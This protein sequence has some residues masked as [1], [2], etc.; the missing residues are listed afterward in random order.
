MSI[1]EMS[2]RHWPSVA[3]AVAL[4][5]LFGLSSIA[6]L[7]IQ[8]LPT[9][10][11]PQV[12]VANFWRAA[13]P[14]EMEANIIEPQENVLRNTPGLTNIS[15]FIG[16][17]QGFIN[18][19][20]AIGTDILR[21]ERVDKVVQRLGDRFVRRILTPE[22]CEE[23]AASPR[24]N[25]LLAKRFAAKEAVLKALGTGWGQGVAWTDVEVASDEGQPRV[26]LRGRAAEDARF[27]PDQRVG[28]LE[29][30]ARRKPLLA[31]FRAVDEVATIVHVVHRDAGRVG[32][33]D[34]RER[35]ER[36]LGVSA[37][38]SGENGG[39]GE[40]QHGSWHAGVLDAGRNHASTVYVRVGGGKVPGSGNKKGGRSRPRVL[41]LQ[42][43]LRPRRPRRRL[44]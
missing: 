5:A 10:E 36:L 28:D 30:G 16:R 26:T 34:T 15:S 13:A 14:E 7:P 25:N 24:P 11:E 33:R 12:S 4:V 31:L 29:R 17:G 39:D 35:G 22:E 42:N 19:S 23:Y 37:S 27:Q 1:T 21:P 2:T 9:I 44:P 8:L 32:S 20:F 41:A 43:A 38:S 18:L 40:Q 3:V 6:S